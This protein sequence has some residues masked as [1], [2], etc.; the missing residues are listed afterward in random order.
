MNDRLDGPETQYIVI[1]GKTDRV[2]AVT[3]L[4]LA[5]PV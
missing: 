2:E 3:T 1:A 4:R 5:H